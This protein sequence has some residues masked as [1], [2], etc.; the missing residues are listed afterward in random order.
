MKMPTAENAVT[1]QMPIAVQDK[2]EDAKSFQQQFNATPGHLNT[3][4]ANTKVD[5]G[6]TKSSDKMVN[7]QNNLNTVDYQKK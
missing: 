3:N 5:S 1:T 2:I 6:K 7:F 4:L